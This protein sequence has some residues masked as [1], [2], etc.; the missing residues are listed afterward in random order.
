MPENLSFHPFKMWTT[1]SGRFS[2]SVLWD[3]FKKGDPAFE[4]V[5][6]RKNLTALKNFLALEHYLKLTEEV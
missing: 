4:L 5:V 2:E 6:L 3:L 1:L